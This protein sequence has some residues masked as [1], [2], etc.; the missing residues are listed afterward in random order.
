MSML[1]FCSA[2]GIAETLQMNS[3]FDELERR[4]LLSIVIVGEQM[5]VAGTDG[6]DTIRFTAVEET[7]TF[8]VSFNGKLSGPYALVR[9]VR[10]NGGKGNDTISFADAGNA[11]RRALIHG[12]AGNDSLIGSNGLDS[13]WGDNGNDNIQGRGW[14]SQL[15]GGNGR[16]RISAAA[17]STFS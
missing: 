3:M 5:R 13:I 15:A 11:I 1:H 14:G 17:S 7:N 10:I 8:K 16:E 4:F 9:S 2:G 12:D 6:A